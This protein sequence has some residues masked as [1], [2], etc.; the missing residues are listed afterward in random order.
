MTGRLE[1]EVLDLALLASFP[2]PHTPGVTGGGGIEGK[3]WVQNTK[4]L[5]RSACEPHGRYDYTPLYVLREIR[6]KRGVRRGEIGPEPEG[7]NLSAFRILPLM[8]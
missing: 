4:G 5:F 7:D 8:H 3:W 1:R 2:L 6:K